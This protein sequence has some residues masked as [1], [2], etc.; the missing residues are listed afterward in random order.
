MNTLALVPVG[1][2][3]YGLAV[4]PHL[5]ALKKELL[6]NTVKLGLAHEVAGCQLRVT[7]VISNTGAG[8]HVPTD[9]PGRQMLLGHRWRWSVARPCPPG[10]GRMPGCLGW[11]TRKSCAMP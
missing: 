2:R 4:T 11:H 10:P 6:E 3:P 1:D 9:F 5:G 7:V 8:H